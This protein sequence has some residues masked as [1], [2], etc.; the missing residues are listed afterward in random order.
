MKLEF[1]RILKTCTN[2]S[3]NYYEN[4]QTAER[5]WK[6]VLISH[7][8]TSSWRTNFCCWLDSVA[9]TAFDVFRNSGKSRFVKQTFLG[10]VARRIFNVFPQFRSTRYLNPKSYIILNTVKSIG[11]F[12][13]KSIYFHVE[14]LSK[15]EFSLCCFSVVVLTE[16]DRLT[17]DAQH[18]L[19]RTMEKYTSTCRLILCCN[20]TSKVIPAIRSR[21]L[22]IRVAA[23]S[24][25]EVICPFLLKSINWQKL[26]IRGQLYKAR[27]A[28]FTG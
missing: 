7:P 28:L 16:V 14:W 22:G 21:C 27:I 24:L 1:C 13:R 26:I 10:V 18:A 11:I 9:F 25:E 12:D 15:H 5:R 17:K 3:E 2:F 6:F 23:P 8:K 19:R 4:H 20:S